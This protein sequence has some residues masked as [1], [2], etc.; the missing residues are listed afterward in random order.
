MPATPKDKHKLQY[1][2]MR[3]YEVRSSFIKEVMDILLPAYKA[4]LNTLSLL[5]ENIDT[6]FCA[7]LTNSYNS[8]IISSLSNEPFPACLKKCLIS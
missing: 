3:F 1:H 5:P 4:G 2:P 7:S 8:Q 6:K